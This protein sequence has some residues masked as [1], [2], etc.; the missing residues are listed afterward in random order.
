MEPLDRRYKDWRGIVVHVVGYDRPGDRVIYMRER[1][2]HECAYPVKRF[3][4]KFT[5]LL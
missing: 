1:Y 2:E 3:K 5:R 4:D